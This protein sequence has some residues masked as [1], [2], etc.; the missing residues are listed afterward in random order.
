MDLDH[1]RRQ[2][3][4]TET[5]AYLF[6]G[7]ISPAARDVRAAAD[8]W[9]E[10]WTYDPLLEF[11]AFEAELEELRSEFAKFIRAEPDQIVIADNTSRA[12]GLAARLLSTQAREIVVDDTTYPSSIYPWL[13]MGRQPIYI[14]TYQAEDPTAEL[15]RQLEQMPPAVVVIS[16]VAPLTGYRHDI[17]RLAASVRAQEGLLFVD[18]AQSTGVLP[19]D[20]KRD[21]IDV[22]VTTAMKWLLG[23]P[24]VAF[25][26]ISRDLLEG[27]RLVEFGYLGARVEGE[28]WPRSELPP[29]AEGARRFE[30][31][32]PSLPGL[33]A[34]TAALRLLAEVGVENVGRQ[35]EALVSRCLAGLHE[36][37][38]RVRTPKLATARAGVIAAEH[39]RAEDVATSL[40]RRAVDVGGYPWGLL[41]IDPHAFCVDEDIDRLLEGL[42][43]FA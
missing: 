41:R 40:R 7:A 12:A 29:L 22:L 42:D 23:P 39:P 20:V 36:R 25:L 11:W 26:Y 1:F 43:D 30:P 24:G 14:P 34:A 17:A 9:S 15:S 31:G 6:A 21:G 35:V 5:R 18:A 19:I 16:H 37:G 10:R 8:R 33:C 2:F 4:I 27:A 38:I 13:V 28:A 32:L 3:P